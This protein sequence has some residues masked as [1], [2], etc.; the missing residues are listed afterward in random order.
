MVDLKQ[1]GDCYRV[2]GC[3]NIFDR[4]AVKN[5][6]LLQVPVPSSSGGMLAIGSFAPG[7][8]TGACPLGMS[9]GACPLGMSPDGGRFTHAPKPPPLGSRWLPVGSGWLRVGT[10]TA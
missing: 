4:L 5:G 6:V 2:D 10:T 1:R 3:R 8:S 7:V 9:T